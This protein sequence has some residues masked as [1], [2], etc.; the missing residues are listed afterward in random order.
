MPLLL[1]IWLLNMVLLDTLRSNTSP[2]DP[3]L[4]ST[5]MEEEP[6]TPLS[7]E[8]SKTH[9]SFWNSKKSVASHCRWVNEKVGTSRKVKVAPSAVTTLTSENFDAL[10]L[11]GKAALVE[12][13]APWW[14]KTTT[15]VQFP[16]CSWFAF[17]LG[18]DTARYSL[19]TAFTR[20]HQISKIVVV[21]TLFIC[22]FLFLDS[23][24]Q[25]REAWP[26]LCWWARCAHRQGRCHWG[27]RSRFQV[28]EKYL[29][30]FFGTEG[31][32]VTDHCICCVCA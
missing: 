10:A 28:G 17:V 26:G 11:G 20:F 8:Q 27:R 21:I 1:V 3:L 5:T 14:V 25:V 6:L 23:R 22:I 13:Y 30:S 2:R 16:L 31:F 7:S 24:S 4:Q 18:A 12:F 29:F 19:W 32:Y 15:T 9:I